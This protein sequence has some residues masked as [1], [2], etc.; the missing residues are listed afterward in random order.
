MTKQNYILIGKIVVIT[1]TT[2]L[3]MVW[4]IPY[5]TG[6]FNSKRAKE[7]TEIYQ[8][9]K[10]ITDS[11][12]IKQQRQIDDNFEAYDKKVISYLSPIKNRLDTTVKVLRN[13]LLTT[14]TKSD[15]EELK[16]NIELLSNSQKKNSILFQYLTEK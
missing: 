7:R 5:V 11:A 1:T 3:N 14:A 15:I 6:Y 16:S 4:S 13:H 9:I 10:S 8:T 2:L 12:F